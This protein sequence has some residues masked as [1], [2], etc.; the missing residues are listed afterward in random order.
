[1]AKWK[2][3]PGATMVRRDDNNVLQT[4]RGGDEVEL[5]EEQEQ[6]LRPGTRGSAF[7]RA[8]AKESEGDSDTEQVEVAVANEATKPADD[9]FQV[10]PT[11]TS[12]RRVTAPKVRTQ[13][14]TNAD[15][16]DEGDL[17]EP[18]SSTRRTG[19]NPRK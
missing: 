9:G 19:S 13:T 6:R 5:T 15:R 17:P 8:D 10:S 16:G 18:T 1:M 11:G 2:L 4:L 3:A 12:N 14:D 7:V